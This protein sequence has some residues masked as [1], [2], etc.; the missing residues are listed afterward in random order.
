MWRPGAVVGHCGRAQERQ[1]HS[2]THK[3]EIAKL[4]VA[5]PRKTRRSAHLAT[6]DGSPVPIEREA[7][8]A[9]AAFHNIVILTGAGLSAE[10]GLGTS[11]TKVDGGR[12]SRSRRWRSLKASPKPNA[13]ARLL[14]S[15][16]AKASRCAAQCGA[17]GAGEARAGSYWQRAYRHAEYR[18]AARGR[19]HAQSHPYAWRA[20]ACSLRSLRHEYALERGLDRRDCLP[21]LRRSCDAA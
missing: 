8:G 13:S 17:Y 5:H 1:D 14:Q 19:R 16:P 4:H 11:A 10:S 3:E 7:R 15:P 21:R 9:V 12:K 2:D 6:S 20:D 18:R